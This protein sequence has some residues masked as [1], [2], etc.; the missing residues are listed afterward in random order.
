MYR[1]HMILWWTGII[2]LISSGLY[3]GIY[4]GGSGTVEAPFKISTPAD[5]QELIATLSDWDKH[6]LLMTDLDLQNLLLTPVGNYSTQFTGIFNGNGHVIHNAAVTQPEGDYVGL[7]GYLGYGGKIHNLRILNTYIAGRNR[8]GGL[9]GKNSGAIVNCYVAGSI[10]AS[11][12]A[13]GLVGDNDGFMIYCYSAGLVTATENTAG[14]LVGWNHKTLTSCDSTSSVSGRQ[15]IGGLVGLNDYVSITSCYA[16]GSA[17]G[18]HYVGG[19]AGE[20]YGSLT[21]CY[22]TGWVDGKK[23]VGGLVGYKHNGSSTNSCFWDIQT[24][25]TYDGVGLGTSDGITGKTTAEMKTP[26][27]FTDAGWDFATVWWMPTDDYPRLMWQRYGSLKI[28]ISPPEALA[29]GAQWRR[30]GTVNWLDSGQIETNVPG[31][32]WEV[33]LKPTAHWAVFEPIQVHVFA[34]TRAE[35]EITYTYFFTLSGYGTEEDPFQIYSLSDLQLMDSYPVHWDKHF[36][37]TNDIDLAGVSFVSVGNLTMQFTGVFNGHGHVIRN[38]II[39]QPEEDF[40]GFFGYVGANGQI[41]N[42]GIEDCAMTG[43]KRVG[44]I[45]GWNEGVIKSCFVSGFVT[46]EED[47]GGLAGRN[48]NTIASCYSMARV[49]GFSDIGGLVGQ[50]EGGTIMSCY[51]AG[52]VAGSGNEIG[53]LVGQVENGHISYSYATGSVTCANNQVGGLIGSNDQGNIEDCYAAGV[54]TGREELLHI[55]GLIGQNTGPVNRCFWDME[56]SGQTASEG[57]KGLTTSQMKSI[58]LFQQFGWAGKGW[59]IQDGLDYPHRDWEGIAGSPIPEAGVVPLAG[60]GTE[61]EPYQIYTASDFALLSWHWSVLDKSIMLMNDLNLNG[62]ELDPIGDMGSFCGKFDGQGHVLWNARIYHAGSKYIGIFGRTGQGGKIH[63]VGVE[64]V[65]MEG[66]YCVGGL[67]GDN[68]GNIINCYT[69]GTVKGQENVGGLVGDMDIGEICDCYAK[70]IATGNEDVG[71]LVGQID[72]GSV[73]RCYTSGSV[74]GM[75]SIGGLIGR[76]DNGKIYDCYATGEVLGK[77]LVG[78]LVGNNRGEITSSYATGTVSDGYVLG[79]LVGFNNGSITACFTSASVSGTCDVGG[80]V[81]ENNSTITSSYTTGV[82]SG[83]GD[84]IHV[85]G[86]VG[87]NHASITTSYSTA[88]VQGIGNYIG[89]LAGTNNGTITSSYTQGT[90]YGIGDYIGGLV[91]ENSST[92]VTC[93]TAGTVVDIGDYVG[94]FCG[95]NAGTISLC[96]WDMETSGLTVSAGGEGKSNEQMRTLSTFTDIGWDF[97][98]EIGNGTSDFWRMCS[99]GTD[100]PR[101]NWQSVDGDFTCPDGINT[102]DLNYFVNN[103]LLNNCITDNNFCGGT[104]LNYSGTVDLFDWVIFADKW[105]LGI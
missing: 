80:L 32:S 90:I 39:T 66:G 71:G 72:S 21:A 3:A 18:T 2:L 103:W 99:N 7:F 43:D 42:L 31:L 95:T 59:I 41:L 105:L 92:I 15:R 10:A 9:C 53:G 34:H 1:R 81:G 61:A 50:M 94:G 104:D 6:F 4:S 67:V 96:F 93:Y 100:Y 27:T 98:N 101:L 55:S 78:G 77:H 76:I 23:G 45:A 74:T 69:L 24:S 56:T 97:A 60:S 37:L 58:I 49:N 75:G 79:G 17:V 91:G 36:A 84:T 87:N 11:G 70:V 82:A 20:N 14:G 33:E 63:D 5:W 8:V 86:L 88:I 22:T 13:G 64:N 102:Q 85:G 57:G 19:L 48:H 35:A 52:S 28:T 89:G 29:E 25:G 51:A 68:D 62:I 26:S 47:I 38:A 30:V 16:A 65:Y 12:Y 54:V 73:G 44:G 46:G 40:I 83:M